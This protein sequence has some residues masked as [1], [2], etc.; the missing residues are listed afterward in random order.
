MTTLHSLGDKFTV[1]L[2]A[3]KGYDTVVTIVF[4][5]AIA[6]LSCKITTDKTY[7]TVF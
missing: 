6:I 2:K 4:A 3:S 7:D 1:F 5:C